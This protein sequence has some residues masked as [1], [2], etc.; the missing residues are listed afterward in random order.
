MVSRNPILALTLLSLS[1][2]PALAEDVQYEGHTLQIDASLEDRPIQRMT[3]TLYTINAP[4]DWILDKA[5]TCATG[6]PDMAN[7]AV[8]AEGGKLEADARFAYRKGWSDHAVKSHFT[9]AASEGHFQVIQSDLGY[10]SDD[11]VASG[12]YRQ[13]V[14]EDGGWDNQI[15]AAIEREQVLID[16]MFR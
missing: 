16:C 8:D 3:G 1:A 10:A 7:V 4:K 11:G 14:Q 13:I 5:R 2:M 6:M 15:D 12:D 9:L